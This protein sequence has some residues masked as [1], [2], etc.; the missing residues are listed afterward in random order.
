MGSRRIAVLAF[1]LTVI[2]TGSAAFGAA[3]VQLT[4]TVWSYS[5]DV[6]LDNIKKFE[7]ANPGIKV[8]LQDFAWE[9]YV[10][11]MT[12]R[13]VGKTPTD[14]AYS[15]DHWLQQW[16]AANWIVPLED[17]FPQVNAYKPDFAPYAIE[18]MTYK[19][20]LYGLPYYADT[21]I[22][23]YNEEMLK[24][25]GFSAPP[26]TWDDVT[27]MALAMK[28]KK[29][30]EYPIMF[31][32]QDITPWYIEV[33][34]S[35]VYSYKDY[36]MF[37]TNLNPIYD[38]EGSAAHKVAQWLVDG[39]R[40]HKIINP[41]SLETTEIPLVKAMGAGQVAFAV[42]PKYNLA[43]LNTPG[44]HAQAGKFKFALMPGESHGTVGF[45]RFYAMTKMAADRG[46]AVREAAWKFLE[47]FG[48]R[49]GNEFVVVK[50]WALDKGL[51]FA[52]LPLYKDPQI[53]AAINKWGNVTL[54][55]QQAKLARAKEALTPFWGSWSLE[56]QKE[57]NKAL[58]GQKSALEALKASAAKWREMKK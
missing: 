54:E 23:I 19:G 11:V 9:K 36:R 49:T 35:M 55:E 51:G 44:A 24:R 12:A 5:T 7:A 10:D 16:A 31:Q 32:F 4:F 26:A 38:R 22:F 53:R 46:P 28:E 1:L 52:Q 58:L 29:I 56:F 8:A 57:M 39:M 41:A 17:Y 18:G 13:F 47:Y 48:G 50:R 21:I 43:D 6:I 40:K 45:V 27:K 30:V 15:S 37:D 34:L 3:P 42:L 20:K 2:L 25:A 33:F 14:L